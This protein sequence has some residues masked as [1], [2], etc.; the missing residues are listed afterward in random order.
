[1][2]LP[3]KT[4]AIWERGGLSAPNRHTVVVRRCPAAFGISVFM[5]LF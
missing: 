5:A 3:Q 2:A 4:L 1:M